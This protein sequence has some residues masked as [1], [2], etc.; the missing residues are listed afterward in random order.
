MTARQ[1]ISILIDARL[2]F[3]LGRNF[4]YKNMSVSGIKVLRIEVDQYDYDFAAKAKG[5]ILL[6]TGDVAFEFDFDGIDVVEIR[7]K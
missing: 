2:G 7:L 4:R 5:A 6:S 3:G 1:R